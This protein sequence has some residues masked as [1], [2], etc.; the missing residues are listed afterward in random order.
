MNKRSL[1]TM[2]SAARAFQSEKINSTDTYP[3]Q[4]EQKVWIIHAR[5]SSAK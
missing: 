1:E 5:A 3:R 2:L 4:Q